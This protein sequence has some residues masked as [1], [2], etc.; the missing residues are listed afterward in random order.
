MIGSLCTSVAKA[1]QCLRQI[2]EIGYEGIEL[3][4][5]M[6][7]PTP[8]MVRLL[9]K[10]AGMPTGKG[11]SFNWKKLIQESGLKVLSLHVDLG[12]LERELDQ[13]ADEA[14]SFGTD[15]V[16][17]TGMYRFDYSSAEAVADLAMR[18]NKVGEALSEKGIHLLYHNHNVEWVKLANGLT[19]FDFLVTSLDERYV[20][21][22]FDSFWPSEAGVDVYRV[23]QKLGKRMKKWH[24][25]DRGNREKGPFM[26][27]ILAS[28]CLELGT[29]NMNLD[30]LWQIATE[31][32][33]ED[34]VLETHR[35]F[36]HKSPMESIRLSYSYLRKKKEEKRWI[37]GH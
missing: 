8:W 30:L 3:N 34:V 26:T 11:G 21:F 2:A 20:N 6:I 24:I 35:N 7:H 31:N 29:G 13:I 4:R 10:L 28:D 17:I 14:K 25:C 32:G 9:T 15:T 18:M 36:I 1:A 16:V 33:V 23:A 22:E 27:P 37:L 12:S 5:F 19:A